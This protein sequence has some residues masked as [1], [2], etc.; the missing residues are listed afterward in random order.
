M[1]VAACRAAAE[2]AAWI[3]N[4]DGRAQGIQG[5]QRRIPNSPSPGRGWRTCFRTKSTCVGG[6]AV[7]V[8][9]RHATERALA[10]EPNLA[11]AHGAK[12]MICLTL[13]WDWE[14]GAA[15]SRE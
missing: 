10:L 1:P 11:A 6:D 12:G 7:A 5:D 8:E 15:E 4:K 2:W 13:E 3:C 9:M 14:A